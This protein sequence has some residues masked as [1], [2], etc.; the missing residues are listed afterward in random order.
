[1]PGPMLFEVGDEEAPLV[2]A[3]SSPSR[4]GEPSTSTGRKATSLRSRLVGL[5]AA[6]A[7]AAAISTVVPS[8]FAQRSVQARRADL[9]GISEHFG[10]DDLVKQTGVAINQTKSGVKNMTGQAL[11]ALQ[12]LRNNTQGK[13][14]QGLGN[15]T[16]ALPDYIHGGQEYYD[17]DTV[18]MGSWHWLSCDY[19]HMYACREMGRLSACCC[20][21]GFA[22]VADDAGS[23]VAKGAAAGAA[24]GAVVSGALMGGDLGASAAAGAAT[25]AV[26]GAAQ[27]AM[28][29]GHCQNKDD[30][31]EAV[32]SHLS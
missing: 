20:R 18:I 1:M 14:I 21:S 22:Y 9:Q 19:D 26:S 31:D 7:S 11:T 28:E 16:D 23:P 29:D 24:G 8:F 4:A 25:G 2:W 12:S 27:Y 13:A 15:A 17:S 30:F 3:E 5:A 6:L 32:R 10:M